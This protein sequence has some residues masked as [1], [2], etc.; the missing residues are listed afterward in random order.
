MPLTL[1]TRNAGFRRRA[2]TSRP[3]GGG[4]VASP[5][6]RSRWGALETLWRLVLLRQTFVYS[7]QHLSIGAG[8]N[9]SGAPAQ[10]I[11]L[12]QSSGGLRDEPFPGAGRCAYLL[13]PPDRR[14]RP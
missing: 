9:S 11:I 10:W 7:C 13:A 6:P 4:T 8:P 12:S 5:P 2:R 14:P 3:A 1:S